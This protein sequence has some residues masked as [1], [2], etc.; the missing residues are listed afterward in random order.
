ML[1]PFMVVTYTIVPYTVVPYTIVPINVLLALALVISE[2]EK[3]LLKPLYC[4]FSP[5]ALVDNLIGK[6]I[7]ESRGIGPLRRYLPRAG[8]RR[9][10]SRGGRWEGQRAGGRCCHLLLPS[11][12]A[13]PCNSASF[14]S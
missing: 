5:L 2:L 6:Q 7:S 11:W 8:W 4:Q 13:S 10:R 14:S 9:P 1:V 3:L 12:P